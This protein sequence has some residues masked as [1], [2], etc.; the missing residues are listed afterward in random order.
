MKGKGIKSLKKLTLR[1]KTIEKEMKECEEL[2]IDNYVALTQPVSN[3]VQSVCSNSPENNPH[4]EGGIYKLAL[5]GKRIVDMVRIGI[6]V[7]RDYKK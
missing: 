5:N 3:F 7:Y 1:K 2:I 6:A 4:V